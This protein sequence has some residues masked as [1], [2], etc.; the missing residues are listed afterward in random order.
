MTEETTIEPTEEARGET[1][2]PQK[3]VQDFSTW[4]N[5]LDEASKAL[6][7][8]HTTG[9]KKALE[10]E[11]ASRKKLSDELKQAQ[12]RAEKGSELE[13]SLQELSR[14]LD[15]ANRRAQFFE[16]APPDLMN[17]RL[18]WMLATA[19]NLFTKKGDPD[20]DAIR[21]KAPEIFVQARRAPSI[22]AGS[23]NSSSPG[24][25]P[26]QSMNNLIRAAAGRV[27]RL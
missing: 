17:P 22:N 27:P 26:A 14:Q 9:L 25:S 21:S 15:E 5:Q 19:D 24:A 1:P 16:S 6:I 4:F 11:R 8:A 10:N 18:A 7:E 13:K 2:A 3:P 23:G 12:L 20:W